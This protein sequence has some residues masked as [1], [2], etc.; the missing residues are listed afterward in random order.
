VRLVPSARHGKQSNSA[1][2]TVAADL[3]PAIAG[4][5]ATI[6]LAVL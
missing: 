1:T 4:L 6:V 2:R 3:P 5:H